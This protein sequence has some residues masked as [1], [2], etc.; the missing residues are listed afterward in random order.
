M[1]TA[2][3]DIHFRQNEP[4]DHRARKLNALKAHLSA[5]G[6]VS[7]FTVDGGNSTTDFSTGAYLTVD[8]GG[9]A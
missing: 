7:T 1:A 3:S 6:S 9:A 8:F 4:D 5:S 2:L